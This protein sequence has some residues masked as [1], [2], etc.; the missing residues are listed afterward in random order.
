MIRRT[1]AMLLATASLFGAAVAMAA[2]AQ[3]DV[4]TPENVCLW[5]DGNFKGEK[6]DDF[7]SR[8]NW[9]T[10]TYGGTSLPLYRGDNVISNVSTIDN[11]DPDTKVSVYYN[12]GYAGPCFRV[13]AYGRVSDMSGITLSNGKSAN[14]VMNSHRF[15]DWCNG[16]TYD[17]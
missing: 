5:S 17:Y 7:N 16:A 4:C 8:T 2:P 12:S 11:W 14:D 3:A 13:A 1:S 15:G 9:S 6:R 10:I